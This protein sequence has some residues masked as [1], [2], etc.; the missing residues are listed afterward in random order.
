ML[1]VE[2]H[3]RGP[4]AL[5]VGKAALVA[6]AEVD[7]EHR[8]IYTGLVYA[9]VP[10]AVRAMLE[11]LMQNQKWDWLPKS[12]VFEGWADQG[13][14]EGIAIGKA[15]GRAEALMVLLAARHVG[16]TS[17]QR[18]R[19]LACRDPRELDTW[20]TRAAAATSADDVLF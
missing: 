17:Q 10:A 20:I 16:L 4:N 1:S 7:L 8:S 12:K 13:R 3:G 18:E 9:A 19:I 15:E 2:A 14:T 5:G 11:E 6:A